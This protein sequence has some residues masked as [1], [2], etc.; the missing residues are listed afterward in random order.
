MHQNGQNFQFFNSVMSGP[1]AFG[2]FSKTNMRILKYITS[3]FF[4][5]YIKSYNI[6][7]AK[8]CLKLNDP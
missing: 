2:M 1:M 7:N 8:S 5:K 4:S 6:S 3:Q